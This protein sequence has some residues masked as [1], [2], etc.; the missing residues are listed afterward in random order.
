MTNTTFDS[1]VLGAAWPRH[2][3]KT[4]AEEM[5]KNIKKVGCLTGRRMIKL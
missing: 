4:I 2:F 5:Y 1:E 3:N